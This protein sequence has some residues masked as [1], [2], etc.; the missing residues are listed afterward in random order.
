M[1]LTKQISFLNKIKKVNFELFIRHLNVA[2]RSA[3]SKRSEN[4]IKREF[5]EY[6]K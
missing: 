6:I 3:S 2:L 1:T 4:V 5:G